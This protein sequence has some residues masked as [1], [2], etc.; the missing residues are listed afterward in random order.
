[1]TGSCCSPFENR[2]TY[3]W[4]VDSG[5]ES[6]SFQTAGFAKL[7]RTTVNQSWTRIVYYVHNKHRT[8]TVITL[9]DDL[10]LRNVQSLWSSLSLNFH[11][12]RRIAFHIDTITQLLPL[13]VQWYVMWPRGQTCISFHFISIKNNNKSTDTETF[14]SS[15]AG[16]TTPHNSLHCGARAAVTLTIFA[17]NQTNKQTATV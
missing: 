7:S 11:Q 8:L 3:V 14:V 15:Y 12:V 9:A 6:P 16:Q 13:H 1:M 2:G 17:N 4:T 5:T 10:W